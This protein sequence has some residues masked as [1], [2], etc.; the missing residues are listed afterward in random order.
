MCRLASRESNEHQ[1]HRSLIKRNATSQWPQGFVFRWQLS[2]TIR[3]FSRS[4]ME[5]TIARAL[6]KWTPHTTY[7][8]QKASGRDANIQIIVD[9][10]KSRNTEHSGG[11]LAYAFLGPQGSRKRP[12][13]EIYYNDTR[14]GPRWT[15]IMLHNTFVHEFGHVLGL[16]HV[17]VRGAMMYESLEEDGR[18]I[19]LTQADINAWRNFSRA[20]S[21]SGRE[22]LITSPMRSATSNDTEV[23]K[24]SKIIKDFWVPPANASTTL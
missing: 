17:N 11:A 10:P 15:T 23:D 21:R 8:F 18:E 5:T 20:T 14:T 2:G 24:K 12:Y 7:R 19:G 22:L 16:D 13:N 1:S 3:G 4:S 9:G 6:Q